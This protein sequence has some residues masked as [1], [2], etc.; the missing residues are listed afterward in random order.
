MY[1][2]YAGAQENDRVRKAGDLFPDDVDQE[3][4]QRIEHKK[5]DQNA[6][7]YM[8]AVKEQLKPFTS[9]SVTV[10]VSDISSVG[11]FGTVE[12]K[13]EQAQQDK[14]AL[15]NDGSAGGNLVFFML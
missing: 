7:G 5:C 13:V 11:V 10:L 1:Q 12:Q 9:G 3:E 15:G 14:Y 2:R 4:D 6:D 8:D